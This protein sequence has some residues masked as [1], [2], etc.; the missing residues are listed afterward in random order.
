MLCAALTA[1]VLDLPLGHTLLGA[2][3]AGIPS[4][5]CVIIGAH[6]V[7]EVIASSSSPSGAGGCR[8]EPGAA[9]VSASPESPLR[10]GCGCGAVRF[11]VR[12]PFNSARYCHCHRCQ[13]RTGTAA[14]VSARIGRADFEILTGAELIRSWEPADGTPK[15]YC[16]ECGGHLFSGSLDADFVA[17]ASAR[18]TATPASAPNPASGSAPPPPGRRSP[19]TACRAT[20]GAGPSAQR[21]PSLIATGAPAASC[22]AGGLN[23]LTTLPF[24]PSPRER[25]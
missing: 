10:G 16:V 5:I 25:A 11:E 13:R 12:A 18:S 14:S 8:G 21:T 2:L 9:R 22:G 17:S 24:R 15:A 1:R 20:R 23:C 7:G 4:V 6:T 19:T 3:L